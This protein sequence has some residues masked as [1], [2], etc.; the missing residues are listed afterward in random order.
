M[1]IP[2][3]LAGLGVAAGVLG[4]G[5]HLSAKETNER[6]Q[7]V[8]EDA[9][10]LYNDAKRSL[11]TSRKKTEDSLMKLGY[12]KKKTLDTSMKIYIEARDKIK[13]LELRDSA[14]MNELINLGLDDQ[15]EL[16][17]REMTD[18]YSSTIQSGAT[19]AA[20]GAVLALAANGSLPIVTSGLATAGSALLAG[21]VGAAAGIA[22]SALS[23]G[24][25]MTPLAAVAA[26]VIFFTG[27]SA[28]MKADENLEKANAMYA[29]AEAAAEKMKVSQV[30]CGAIAERSDMFYD[31]L[32]KLDGMF[33]ECS[34]LLAAVIRKREGRFFKKKLTMA[35]FTAQDKKLM[36]VTGALAKAVKTVIDT[37]ILS[38][39]GELTEESQATVEAATAMLPEFTS[40]VADVRCTNYGVRAN[41]RSAQRMAAAARPAAEGSKGRVFP[42]VLGVILAEILSLSI[43]TLYSTNFH[44]F[45]FMPM[46][47]VNAIVIWILTFISTIILGG[48]VRSDGWRSACS[49]I[50]AA[51]SSILYVQFCWYFEWFEHPFVVSGITF[52]ILRFIAN[53]LKNGADESFS[54][55]YIYRLFY[56]FRRHPQ[57]FWAYIFFATPGAD[58]NIWLLAITGII[59]TVLTFK[60]MVAS[61]S[62]GVS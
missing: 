54:G 23:V 36:A 2:F 30:M 15:G 42:Y 20:A 44:S 13:H 7:R 12:A 53:R 5:G 41:V 18:I 46:S 55:S 35:S 26:P 50:A 10:E 29:Q 45:L 61:Y 32:Q 38:G 39:E 40:Q 58:S 60:T 31:L 34:V 33:T 25:A 57:W 62:G 59:V 51:C 8:A 49:M 37:P 52:L 4:A 3:L 22:G 17:I 48:Q 21:E 28:S 43:A 24:A 11:E 1:P 27:L 47:F 9:Q 16:Q 19:G 14:G 56:C 6:A